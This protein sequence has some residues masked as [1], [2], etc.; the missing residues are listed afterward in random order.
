MSRRPWPARPRR[1][2]PGSVYGVTLVSAAVTLALAVTLAS[3]G[4]DDS[5]S[6]PARPDATTPSG[7]PGATG[8]SGSKDQPGGGSEGESDQPEGDSGGEQPEAGGQDPE[9]GGQDPAEG[10]GPGG[11]PKQVT[12]SI[13]DFAFKPARVRVAR[14]GTIMWTNRSRTE[15]H[16]AVRRSGPGQAPNSGNIG[17]GEGTY[18]DFFKSSGTVRYH[19]TYHP[20]MRGVVVVE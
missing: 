8:P 7:D 17:L 9:G 18:T 14:G 3:C 4:D 16:T 1:L 20:R 11:A 12:V 13:T 19:C 6:E 2:I 10:A 15:N 5:G